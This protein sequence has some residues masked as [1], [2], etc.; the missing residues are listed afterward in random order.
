MRLLCLMWAAAALKYFHTP[1]LLLLGCDVGV[2]VDANVSVSVG[3]WLPWQLR[4][5][6]VVVVVAILLSS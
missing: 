3:T 5:M 1:P 4:A 6:T 2:S